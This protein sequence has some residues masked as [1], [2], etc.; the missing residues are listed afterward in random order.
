MTT[1]STFGAHGMVP[2][3]LFGEP[4]T[5]HSGGV[6]HGRQLGMDGKTLIHPG[7]IEICNKVFSPPPE[8]VEDA[9]KIIAAFAAQENEGKGVINLD[10]G[11]VELLHLEM[12][13]NTV[14]IADAVA[15]AGDGV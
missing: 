1:T 13:R 9:R 3:E 10:G 14:A 4:Q 5:E 11:M 7:Q 2:H 8:E 12:A 15:E 6:R